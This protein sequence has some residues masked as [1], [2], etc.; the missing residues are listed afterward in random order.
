LGASLIEG[1]YEPATQAVLR[2]YLRP[3][4]VFIDAGANEGFFTVLGAQLVGP[5]GKVVAVEPQSRLQEVIRKNLALN[6]CGNAHLVQAGL[7][8]RPGSFKL[9]LTSDMNNGGSSV[10]RATRYKLP[11]EEVR[12]ITLTQLLG[13]A[14]VTGCQ[15]MKVDIEGGEYDIFLN[16]GDILRSGALRNIALEIHHSIL[17]KQ[18]LDGDE[19]HRFVL[20]CGYRL[21]TELGNA[22]YEFAKQ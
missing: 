17:A 19:I 13:E 14:G 10:Y 3:G 11:E 6:S 1:N 21:D 22:V 16:A 4:D 20:G 8:S 15:L 12:T 5:A 9:T 18:G 2:K 7:A